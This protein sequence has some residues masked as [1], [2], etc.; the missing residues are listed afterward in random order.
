MFM[1]TSEYY[2]DFTEGVL[3]EAEVGLGLSPP[4]AA[5]ALLTAALASW[6]SCM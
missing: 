1:M 6:S 5:R 2:L 3:L 4:K